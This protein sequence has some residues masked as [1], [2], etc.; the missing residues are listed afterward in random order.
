M[1]GQHWFWSATKVPEAFDKRLLGFGSSTKH[2]KL[3]EGAPCTAVHN[4]VMG[5]EE[6][7][8]VMGEALRLLHSCTLLPRLVV[9]DL[10]YTLW[11]FWWSVFSTLNTVLIFWVSS[12]LVTHFP[13]C[14]FSVFLKKKKKKKKQQPTWIELGILNATNL[15]FQGGHLSFFSSLL[16]GC[17]NF[18]LFV[19][20][21]CFFFYA[22]FVW[23]NSCEFAFCQSRSM[24]VLSF[25]VWLW[26]NIIH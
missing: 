9:F 5:K 24:Y 22:V 10:D 14:D 17:V 23:R 11:P 1:S 20:K 3:W 26:Q 6:E 4:W 13:S 8:E 19:D 7:E 25:L 21:V 12:F 16:L 15:Y 2:L 18:A